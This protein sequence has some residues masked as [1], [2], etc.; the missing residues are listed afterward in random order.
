[1]IKRFALLTAAGLLAVLGVIGLLVPVIPGILFLLMAAAC[2]SLA[3]D[4]VHQ[5]MNH[6]PAYRRWRRRW[7]A[8][9]G[10]STWNRIKLSFWLSVDT[11]VKAF[12]RR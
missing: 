10:L 1:M 8:S 6:N 3:S 7:D 5:K 12:S 2:A 9:A 4:R 11:T